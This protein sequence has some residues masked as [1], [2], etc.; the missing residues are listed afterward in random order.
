MWVAFKLA[1]DS[2]KSVSLSSNEG[3]HGRSLCSRAGSADHGH[4]PFL[5]ALRE[6]GLLTEK[7]P[8]SELGVAAFPHYLDCGLADQDSLR[9][10][11]ASCVPAS[12]EQ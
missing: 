7:E 11:L 10:T 6:I 12:K 5:E 4:E 9:L 3:G 1:V 8:I 2:K